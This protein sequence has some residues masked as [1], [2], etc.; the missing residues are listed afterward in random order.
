MAVPFDQSH[1]RSVPAYD[2]RIARRGN[3]L[4]AGALIAALGVLAYGG[5]KAVDA[6]RGAGGQAVDYL[7][8]HGNRAELPPSR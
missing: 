3:I 6:I 5:E 2:K 4:T 8:N 1:E 7:N